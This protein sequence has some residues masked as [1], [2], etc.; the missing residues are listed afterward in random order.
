MR[1]LDGITDSMDVSLSELRELVMDREAWCAAIHGVTKSRTRLGD[2]NELKVSACCCTFNLPASS[3]ATSH[4]YH[5]SH[6]KD[7]LVPYMIPP[8]LCTFSTSF[9]QCPFSVLL[10]GTF[11]W[12]SSW[13]TSLQKCSFLFYHPCKIYSFLGHL[14]LLFLFLMIM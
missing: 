9:L 7:W 13:M 5:I 6:Y 4:M 8:L 2:W 11:L 3:S 12:R 14:S 10:C 1:W